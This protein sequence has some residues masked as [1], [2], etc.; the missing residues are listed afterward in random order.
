MNVSIQT[1]PVV[2]VPVASLHPELSVDQANFVLSENTLVLRLSYSGKERL[3][4]VTVI[5]PGEPKT[6]FIR[7]VSSRFPGEI[8]MFRRPAPRVAEIALQTTG[9]TTR[10]TF[11]IYVRVSSPT[12]Q[13]PMPKGSDPADRYKAFV[14][15]GPW[16]PR[17]EEEETMAFQCGRRDDRKEIDALL[18]K[19][20]RACVGPGDLYPA[21]KFFLEYDYATHPLLLGSNP[22]LK[23]PERA[24]RASLVQKFLPILQQRLR[25]R[26]YC[27]MISQGT[28]SPTK[29]DLGKVRLTSD[30]SGID[31]PLEKAEVEYLSKLQ[32]NIIERHYPETKKRELSGLRQAFENFADGKLREESKQ[33]GRTRAGEPSSAANGEP[34]SAHLFFF[35]EFACVAID[36]GVDAKFW[37][38]LLPIFSDIQPIYANR[39]RSQSIGFVEDKFNEYGGNTLDQT[40][41]RPALV[42][43]RGNGRKEL[44][45]EE[46]L[47]AI[48]GHIS[49]AFGQ[50]LPGSQVVQSPVTKEES[51]LPKTSAAK[52]GQGGRSLQAQ[53]RRRGQT[54]PSWKSTRAVRG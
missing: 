41:P 2:S 52:Q 3:D 19:L 24:I 7:D 11:E 27:A 16:P 33:E 22:I 48:G 17:Y 10:R 31:A 54:A 18:S 29:S 45:R 42:R 43:V 38:D 1:Q 6:V 21:K 12:L 46:L 39:Y 13:L 49:D 9:A 53:G 5:F 26:G 34:D 25:M 51:K 40:R 35:A 30:F 47:R 44:P 4:G 20:A 23:D 14:S 50:Y 8:I 37:E 32:R 36:H 28:K 15:K